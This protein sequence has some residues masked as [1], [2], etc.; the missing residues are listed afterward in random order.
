MT[1]LSGEEINWRN[2]EAEGREAERLSIEKCLF[3]MQEAA[4]YLLNKLEATE[5][6]VAEL[7]GAIKLSIGIK[8]NVPWTEVPDS[9][10]D[11]WIN[12]FREITAV[13]K[14]E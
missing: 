10:V 4:K 11:G 7:E 6:R 2:S 1:Y 3:Q 8:T 9:E 5:K 13:D 12:G 14:P